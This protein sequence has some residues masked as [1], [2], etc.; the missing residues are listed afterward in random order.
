MTTPAQRH[1]LF[2][3]Y[4]HA[5]REWV[6]RLQTM[7]R[8][9][10][11]SDDLKLWDDSQIP[12]GARWREEIEKA[13]ATAKVALL[14]VSDEF[15]A[16]EF[17]TNKELPPLLEA[18]EREGL[19]ILWVCLSP[20]FV[21]FTPINDFQAVLPPSQVL[22]GMSPVDQK[23]ALKKVA[24][25][26]REALSSSSPAAPPPELSKPA[27]AEGSAP[28][29]PPTSSTT[30]TS[31]SPPDT[32]TP[33]AGEM[34]HGASG[35]DDAPPWPLQSMRATSCLLLREGNRWRQQ[36][37]TVEV[38][39]YEEELA[40]GVALTLV[41]ISAGTFLMGSP[42]EEEGRT[43]RE[44]SAAPGERPGVLPG[45]DADHP[46][47]VEGGRRAGRRWSWI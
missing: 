29:V 36:R 11:R 8:P 6:D 40:P 28:S 43:E 41:R 25:S 23:Q 22:E 31:P 18:A 30:A 39:G 1:Q 33:G 15:L 24:L 38:Q 35:R 5:D 19:R 20:C 32:S 7:I 14:L 12:P 34:V 3:S 17:V 45:P 13:L 21:E 46:G 37:T 44:E 4:S 10:V 42:E 26:I 9:L 47:P 16:S 27:S 2:I